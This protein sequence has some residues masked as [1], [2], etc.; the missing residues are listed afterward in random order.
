VARNGGRGQT[1]P[2]AQRHAASNGQKL[3][4]EQR[5]QVLDWLARGWTLSRVQVALQEA[6][7][8]RIAH[9]TLSGYQKRHAEEIRQKRDKWIAGLR[10]EPLAVPRDRLRELLKMYG[11]GVLAQYRELCPQC[12]GKG[13]LPIL[14]QP[15]D[16]SRKPVEGAEPILGEIRCE[17]CRGR[18]WVLPAAVQAVVAATDGDI[19][20]DTLPTRPPAADPEGLEAL[21]SILRQ[22]RE[23]VGDVWS[24]RE[25]ST[26][27]DG[28]LVS[29]DVNMVVI[30]GD[31]QEYIAKL[32]AMRGAPPLPPPTVEVSPTSAVGNGGPPTT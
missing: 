26:K 9:Q 12:G 16:K 4:V 21:R 29:G 13:T 17:T 1:T 8:P 19:R 27:P 20:L 32:R 11:I 3:S 18:K 31:K 10:G 25:Q 30:T 22:I 24:P 28:N 5:S 14:R 2:L 15:V 6:G 23:E 7:G